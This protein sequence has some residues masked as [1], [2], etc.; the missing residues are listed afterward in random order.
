MYIVVNTTSSILNISDLNVSIPPNQSRDLDKMSLSKSPEKSDDLKTAINNHYLKVVKKDHIESKK[1]IR[2][3]STK[4]IIHKET[5]DEKKLA[6]MFSEEIRKVKEE[7]RK[8]SS[9]E[10]IQTIASMMGELLKNNSIKQNNSSNTEEEGIEESM[11]I[12]E[13]TQIHARAI[14]KLSQDTENKIDYEQEKTQDNS[15][16]DRANELEGLL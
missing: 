11:D 3:E 13:L 16:T 7:E 4:K 10:M 8:N 6:K 5:I 2:I 1:E 14:R 15:F 12:K 9:E